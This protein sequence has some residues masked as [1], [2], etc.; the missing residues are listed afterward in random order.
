MTFPPWFELREA[1]MRL[2]TEYLDGE[3]TSS[4]TNELRQLLREV[5][6]VPEASEAICFHG[7]NALI[8]EL[9]GDFQAA[10]SYRTTEIR[11]IE[12]L[13]ELAER[14][15]GDRAALRNYEEADLQIRREILKRLQ[16]AL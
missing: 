9:D 5:E 1:E 11:K 10:I 6:D 8:S 7:A 14:N 16:G 13:H 3:P 2:L 15:P 4:A 12:Y